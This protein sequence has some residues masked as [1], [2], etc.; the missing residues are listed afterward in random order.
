MAKL[1]AKLGM[2]VDKVGQF[3]SSN[4]LLPTCDS[5]I[6]AVCIIHSSQS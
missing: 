6:I 5:D 2:I 3:F 1:E 4:D